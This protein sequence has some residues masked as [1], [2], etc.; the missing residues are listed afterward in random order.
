MGRGCQSPSK[1][2]RAGMVFV[3]EDCEFAT[4]GGTV[5]QCSCGLSQTRRAEFLS[6][7]TTASDVC[8]KPL[9]DRDEGREVIDGWGN[10]SG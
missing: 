4:L 3:V 6:L 5:P 10:G 8:L 9:V 2:T 1:E 7:S